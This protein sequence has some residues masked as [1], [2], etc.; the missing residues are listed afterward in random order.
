MTDGQGAGGGADQGSGSGQSGTEGSSGGSGYWGY[1]IQKWNR[2][3]NAWETQVMGTKDDMLAQWPSYAKGM[4]LYQLI[5]PERTVIKSYAP[6]LGGQGEG[7]T[8]D[9]SGGSGQATGLTYTIQSRAPG[10]SWTDGA[11]GSDYVSLQNQAVEA[12][13]A[14]DKLDYQV[15]DNN[16]KVYF[17]KLHRVVVTG[18]SGT[19]D[20]D[21]L[22]TVIVLLAVIAVVGYAAVTWK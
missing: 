5:D 8:E 16:G 15:I 1:Q 11:S 13:N 6:E 20:V 9:Q 12:W 21:G 10:G 14:N 7:G 3:T 18:G 4:E 19:F 22:I 2:G 17:T